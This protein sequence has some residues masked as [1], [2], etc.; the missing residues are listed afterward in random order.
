MKLITMT[1][2]SPFLTLFH[3]RQLIETET[4]GNV[5]QALQRWEF[6]GFNYYYAL[7]FSLPGFDIGSKG[8]K[9]CKNGIYISTGALL[10]FCFYVH[11]YLELILH[12]S[13]NGK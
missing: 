12:G 13:K 1:A 5:L 6:F 9:V 3:V 7:H 10:L 4:E 11:S 8:L 2:P